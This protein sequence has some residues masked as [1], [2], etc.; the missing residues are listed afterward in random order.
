[1]LPA[2]KRIVKSAP[3]SVA[4]PLRRVWG[5]LPDELKYGRAFRD[6]V[7]LLKESEHWDEQRLIAFQEQRLRQ[8]VEHAYA[9]VPY[10]RRV[11]EERGL[12]PHDI[13]KV[14]DLKK[15]PY[16]T[17]AIVIK[18]KRNL[19]ATNLSWLR[20]EAVHTAG[21]TGSPLDFFYDQ[22]TLAVNKALALRH[23]AWVG[24]KAGDSVAR[25]RDPYGLDPERLL[26]RDLL[27]RELKLTLFRAD[28]QE[29]RLV[30]Q[31]IAKF[32]PTFISAWPSCLYLLA[33][34]LRRNG[35][36]LKSPKH[37]ITSSE[38]VYPHMRDLIE[39]AFGAPLSDWYGQEESVAVA[40]Q[41]PEAGSYHIQM[42]MGIVELAPRGDHFSEIVGTCLQN[43]V[44]PFIRYK[45]GD[46]AKAGDE[47]CPCGRHHPILA[48]I[49]GREGDFIVTPDLR[50]V[51]PLGLNHVVYH[52]EEIR[53]SQLVQEDLDLL[54]I[55]VVPWE[56][57]SPATVRAVK[58][59][60]RTY[61]RAPSM[62]IRAEVVEE[63]P[64]T[65]TGKKPFVVS[66]L[67]GEASS[68]R[69]L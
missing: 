21:S 32:R 51:S 67:A 7:E 68:W 26:E 42:E 50:L 34:W 40:M 11:L 30:A 48:E 41:C 18:E 52:L 13:R 54:R 16:L 39:E 27:G 25:F 46:L 35:V 43:W 55:K 20:R 66:K 5:S 6:A 64:R 10:Y 17:R 57:L 8:L 63:I 1:M 56:A 28:D 29:L 47:A 53:E 44:M 3:V 61:L 14:D 59:R 58:E 19:L 36:R 69:A 22:R 4:K 2:L 9:H 37:L 49:A 24:Y 12:K 15:L 45:T 62:R 38:N 33:R 31:G 60:I 23:L 65:S